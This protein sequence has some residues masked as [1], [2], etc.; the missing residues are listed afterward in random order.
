MSKIYSVPDEL[1]IIAGDTVPI[2][3]E[4]YRE[5]GGE[6][7]FSLPGVEIDWCL[8]LWEYPDQLILKKSSTDGGISVDATNKNNFVVTLLP[9]DTSELSGVFLYQ[10][11]IT[12]PSGTRSRRVQ[13][14]ITIAPIIPS[15]Y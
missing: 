9:E 14:S 12:T 4:V 5:D 6:I 2:P 11:G 1:E 8:S 13:G 15:S 7:N 3:Y 10:I